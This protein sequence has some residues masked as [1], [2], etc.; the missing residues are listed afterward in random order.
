MHASWILAASAG[1]AL[2]ACRST[3][4]SPPKN[5]PPAPGTQETSEPIPSACLDLVQASPGNWAA[6]LPRAAALGAEAAPQLLRACELHPEGAGIQAAIHLLGR[7]GGAEA[8]AYL[9]RQLQADVPLAEEAALA[10]GRMQHQASREVLEETMADASLD[11]RVRAAACAARIDLGQIRACLP[12]IRALFQA[13]TPFGQASSREQ[14]FP[15]RKVRWAHERYM[16]I[17]AIRRNLGGESFG[18]DEDAP[19]PRLRSG[20]QALERA[21]SEKR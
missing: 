19:W 10:L 20:L 21:L 15:A 11:P 18:L 2:C 4:E 13:A 1:I 3:P 6:L 17:E 5:G 12:F 14:G 9:H 7:W 8:R 16:V